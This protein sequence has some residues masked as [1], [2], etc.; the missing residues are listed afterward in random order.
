MSLHP[1]ILLFS[2]AI[3]TH[4]LAANPFSNLLKKGQECQSALMEK[5]L[6]AGE[7]LYPAR[8]VEG[9]DENSGSIVSIAALSDFQ[10]LIEDPALRVA[11]GYL[12]SVIGGN[13]HFFLIPR[14]DFSSIPSHVLKFLR[15]ELATQKQDID[16]TLLIK[17]VGSNI[18]KKIL[19]GVH[20]TTSSV[21]SM[22]QTEKLAEKSWVVVPG[23]Y[24]DLL[25]LVLAKKPSL[26]D[27]S[28]NIQAAVIKA[29]QIFKEL[30]TVGFKFNAPN[31]SPD[32][33]KALFRHE[34]ASELLVEHQKRGGT[35][36][37]GSRAPD[38]ETL[39]FSGGLEAL[40]F[41]LRGRLN[42]RFDPRSNILTLAVWN[43]IVDEIVKPETLA[44]ADI[45]DRIFNR[46]LNVTAHH[47]ALHSAFTASDI[48]PATLL[49]YAKQFIDEHGGFPQA[50]TSA[51]QG[52]LSNLGQ[53]QSM[54]S[55]ST[56]WRPIL[57]RA[58]Q[59]TSRFFDNDE[60]LRVRSR[61]GQPLPN[62]LV[63]RFRD[64]MYKWRESV[65]QPLAEQDKI[66]KALFE[67]LG[68][69]LSMEQR[70]QAAIA[71]QILLVFDE[72]LAHAMANRESLEEKMKKLQAYDKWD[73]R[74]TAFVAKQNNILKVLANWEEWQQ[75]IARHREVP[76]QP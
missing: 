33:L 10:G 9:G 12:A 61:L 22:I 15:N 68:T 18:L 38:H 56:L 3:S 44:Q 65:S 71:G 76:S 75:R 16:P 52:R 13:T 43:Q 40:Q 31:Q 51:T 60:I 46:D 39:A 11:L 14:E 48:V 54:S 67:L 4:I 36:R 41:H 58:R 5:K 53:I 2:L 47:E 28:S 70:Y 25:L 57:L 6:Q 42:G 20:A 69:S 72:T 29:E 27:V 35:F 32:T 59:S 66:L 24:V 30:E 62:H 1:S 19:P 64:L 49:D 37:I 73:L 8:L 21:S 55:S 63:G 26:R 23:W 34:E 17:K 50:L 74:L 45:I 7:K